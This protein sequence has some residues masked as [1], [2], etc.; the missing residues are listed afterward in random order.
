MK[1]NPKQISNTEVGEVQAQDKKLRTAAPP[2]H[3][4]FVNEGKWLY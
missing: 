4:N 1:S 2:P 3:P